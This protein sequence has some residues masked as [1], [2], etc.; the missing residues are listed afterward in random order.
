MFGVKLMRIRLDSLAPKTPRVGSASRLKGT[1]KRKAYETPSNSRAKAEPG[2]SPPTFKTPYKPGEQ[3]G[4]TP[5][6]A[7]HLFLQYRVNEI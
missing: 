2:S 1:S 6:Y 7:S 5:L 3:N 4:S